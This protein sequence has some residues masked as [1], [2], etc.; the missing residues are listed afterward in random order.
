LDDPGPGG[1][2]G[3]RQGDHGTKKWPGTSGNSSV[4]LVQFG[5]SVRA[6]AITAG[7]LNRDT[8]SPHFNDQAQRCAD[9]RDVY[10]YPNQ[11]EG[12]TERAY[13]PGG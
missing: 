7:G 3:G 13:H 6:K 8:Q 11:L 2:E 4:A 5:D 1:S 10:F 12:H 9:L